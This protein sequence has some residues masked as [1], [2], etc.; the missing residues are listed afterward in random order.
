[1]QRELPQYLATLSAVDL[2]SLAAQVLGVQQVRVTEW[3]VAQLGGSAH[4]A[5]GGLGVFRVSGT[6]QVK[7]TLLPW[8]LIAKGASS[9]AGSGSTDPSAPDYWKRETLVY[10]T[11]LLA[12]LPGSLAAPRCYAVCEPQPEEFWL[13]L[14]EVH[15]TFRHWTLEQFGLVARHLGQFNG[16]YLAGTPLPPEA[17]AWL[18]HGRLRPELE[19]IHANL[20]P[21]E[22]AASSLGQKLIRASQLDRVEKLLPYRPA[23][24]QEVD[25][26]PS[27]FCHLDSFRRNLLIR[28]AAGGVAET[29]AIDW[30]YA[31]IGKVGEDAGILA[32]ASLYWMEVPASQAR[33]LAQ[34]VFDGYSAGLNDAGWQGNINILRFGYCISV[35][36]GI[37]WSLIFMD[38]LQNAENVGIFEQI[39]GHPIGDQIAQLAEI[40]PFFLDMGDEAIAL[41]PSIV[42]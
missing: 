25:R 36:M 42:G 28:K 23:L 34:K 15:E 31:G 38:W 17:H 35:A 37:R 10:Q 41:L 33:A 40:Q 9:T 24:L 7:E 8:S 39:V 11:G 14:E 1:M 6:A 18:T 32:K 26:L 19:R 2:E 16:A 27:C 3:H 5:E 21:S 22:F 30:A 20:P 12:H 29:V 13:W 4:Y